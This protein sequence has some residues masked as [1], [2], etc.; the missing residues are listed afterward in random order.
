MSTSC[1]RSLQDMLLLCEAV[2]APVKPEK[3]LGPSTTLPFLGIL[4]DSEKGEARLP[5]DKLA[6]LKQE[7]D[8]FHSLA[9][10]HKQCSKRQFLSLIGKLAF[11]CK[12]IPAGPEYFSVDS[13]TPPTQWMTARE[14]TSPTHHHYDHRRT[15]LRKDITLTNTSMK[16]YIK[17]SKTDQ[18][19][20]TA[21]VL[22]GKTGTSTYLPHQRHAQISTAKR[23][24]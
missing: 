21:V 6:A 20:Q 18:Y 10:T 15:L 22:I 14:Y 24:P 2:Q 13:W 8:E 19:R 12:V 17:A 11:A 1:A 5:E 7:L 3:V 9:I 16:V 4:L 23:K